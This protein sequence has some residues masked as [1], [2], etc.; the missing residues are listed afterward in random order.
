[1]DGRR[2][3]GGLR[4]GDWPGSW[5]LCSGRLW[6]ACVR[7]PMAGAGADMS[8]PWSNTPPARIWHNVD[9]RLF[10][11]EIQPLGRP[12]VLRGLV[13]DWPAVAAAARGPEALC[14]LLKAASGGQPIDYFEAPPSAQGRYAYTPDMRGFNFERRKAGLGELLDRLLAARSLQ[15]PPSLYAGAVN[16]P[17]HAPGLLADHAIPLLSNSEEK[18]VS[19]WI[20]NRGRTPAHWDLPQNLACVISGRR[21][22]TLFPTEQVPNLYIGPLDMT[23]AG[24][25]SSLVDFHDPDFSLYP[26]FRNAVDA[27]EIA[28][29]EPGDALY[30]PS[31]W[32]HHVEARDS[33]GVMMNIWWREGPSHLVT[34]FLTMLHALMTLRD[35]PV[36]EREAWRGLFEHYIFETNGD[37]FAHLPEHARGMFGAMT[38]ERQL[39]IRDHLMRS[40]SRL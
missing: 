8:G 2:G 31:L 29:L 27:A 11:N 3:A 33:F 17:L 28:D 16:V 26:K 21:R 9:Q 6:L 36:R 34:P 32:I 38:R 12:A 25:P 39:A 10:L 4:Q 23:L 14:D 13:S 22:F 7:A 37:P 19:L 40:L 15:D 1:M 5:S 35:L 24:Q 18:L 30:M 20:G